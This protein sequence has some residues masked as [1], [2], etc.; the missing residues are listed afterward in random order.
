MCSAAARRISATGGQHEI[1]WMQ[2]NSLTYSVDLLQREFHRRRPSEALF[3]VTQSGTTTAT[4][5]MDKEPHV[6][7]PAAVWCNACRA[8]AISSRPTT[9]DF[10]TRR[11]SYC[12]SQTTVLTIF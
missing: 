11:A 3:G 2:P 9:F 10:R 6:I 4:N 1:P 5:N 12:F 8:R 7:V